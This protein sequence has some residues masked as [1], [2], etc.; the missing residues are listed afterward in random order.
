LNNND[1]NKINHQQK[2]EVALVIN[3]TITKCKQGTTFELSQVLI[4]KQ[5]PEVS[6]LGVASFT[7]Q[8]SGLQW[9]YVNTA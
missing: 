5:Q 4:K 3:H 2:E 1:V 6:G 9:T 8:N 7:D